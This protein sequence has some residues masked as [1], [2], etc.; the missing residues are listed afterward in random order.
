MAYT[1]PKYEGNDFLEWYKSNF[2]VD[3]T[4]GG[5]SRQQ[6]MSDIDWDIGNELYSAYQQQQARKEQYDSDYQSLLG[7]YQ[8]SANA[9]NSQY[10]AAKDNQE[11]SY[12]KNTADL[13]ANYQSSV[14]DLDTSRKNALQGASITYD[15]LKKYL[16]T[17]VKAQ[18][19]GGLGV[20]EST[21]LQAHNTYN[22]Q[23]GS[24]ENSYNANKATL[25]NAYSTNKSSLDTAHGETLRKLESDK[26]ASDT[27]RDNAYSSDSTSL[28][29]RYNADMQNIRDGVNVGAITA[30]YQEKNRVLQQ[31]N[32]DDLASLLSM[33]DSETLA[34]YYARIEAADINDNQKAL[35]KTLAENQVQNNIT[36]RQQSD[37]T[38]FQNTI[39]NLTDMSTEAAFA[40]ID[41][42][43]ITAQQKAQLKTLV[44]SQVSQNVYNYKQE[45]R[46]EGLIEYNSHYAD[47]DYVE[48]K[49]I[50]DSY[51]QYLSDDEYQT[52]VNAIEQK[53]KEQTEAEAKAKAEEAAEKDKR[54]ISGQETF[55]YNGGTYQITSQ[56]KSDANE[57]KRNN[58]FKDQLKSKCGTT[59][60][61][62]SSKIPNGTTFEIK[63]D[64]RGSNDFNFWDDIGAFLLS[65]LGAGAWDSWGN[66]NTLYVTF[67]NGQWYKSDKKV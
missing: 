1:K 21:L 62:D 2:G 14:G 65:P 29:N 25:E 15:K 8:N 49:K 24:I 6:G 36:K 39:K 33:S 45:M 64:N 31:G 58:D 7:Q 5:L 46:N 20:S 11:A 52:R 56:L 3:Y 40:K 10:Q 54:I 51:K 50:L 41:Q 43:D 48:A 26:L 61:Y 16:P 13:L 23:R 22:T 12:S 19:L 18:G 9:A 34:D 59:D 66:W 32:Y 60:P 53:V 30:D 17:Q 38:N 57:I 44:E 42:L 55:E 35:L 67:Y 4:G 28:L 27:A 63:A 37:F 47:G